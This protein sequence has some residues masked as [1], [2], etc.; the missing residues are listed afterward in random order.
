MIGASKCYAATHTNTAQ[1]SQSVI[2]FICYPHVF[3]FS[4]AV[5]IHGCKHEDVAIEA[6][7]TYM[8]QRH[9]NFNVTKCGTFIDPNHPFLHATPDFLRECD[10]CGLCCGEVKCPYCMEGCDFE[11]YCTKKSL[12]LQ[13]DSENFVLKREHPYYCQVLQQLNI[14]K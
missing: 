10:C 9:V 3:R 13:P 14:T 7:I 11:D 5:T 8:K 1:S 6:Y 2:K 12:C 4:M